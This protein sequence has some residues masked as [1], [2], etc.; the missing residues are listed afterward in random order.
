MKY[1][2]VLSVVGSILT[3]SIILDGEVFAQSKRLEYS[4]PLMGTEVAII[5]YARDSLVA[6]QAVQ[7][8]ISRMRELNGTL[9]DY[10]I[11][12]EVSQLSKTSNQSVAVSIDLWNVL[13]TAQNISKLSQGAFD[14]TVGPLTL[15]W[16][17]AMRRSKFPD[18]NLIKTASQVVGYNLIEVNENQPIVELKKSKMR[19]DL[20]GIAK[21]FVA[22][23]ALKILV[24]NGFPK[25]AVDAGGDIALGEAPPNSEG[26]MIQVFEESSNQTSI[27]LSDCGIAVSGNTYRNLV[28]DGV[29]Y[30]H[31]VDPRT[32]L[33]V[34]HQRKVA[35]IAPNAMTAD[36][37]AS[38]Y[39]V[40]EWT[41]AQH[42]INNQENL[43]ILMIEASGKTN[44]RI[45]TGKF[46]QNE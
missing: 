17:K 27:Y 21:G 8:A 2:F 30:S 34:T 28:H 5:L 10:L 18:L 14:V 38:T 9:S 32:G 1:L 22:D 43:Q 11:N 29:T 12:S 42:S 19:I 4:L 41:D 46:L 37:W 33:G 24:S 26:W 13:L 25:A 39:S 7:S 44:R 3:L 36:A 35:V 40:M 15:I 20:G 6:E 31:I 45:I 23:Q 16:R